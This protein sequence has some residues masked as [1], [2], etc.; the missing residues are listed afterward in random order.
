M[1]ALAQATR[2]SMASLNKAK[3]NTTIWNP[4]QVTGFWYMGAHTP[5]RM[6]VPEG[7]LVLIRAVDL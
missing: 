2:L 4:S 1:N 7:F 3:L 5:L 6:L